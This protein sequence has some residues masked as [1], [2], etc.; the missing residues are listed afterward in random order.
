MYTDVQKWG[1]RVT[2]ARAFDPSGGLLIDS[3]WLLACA[4]AKKKKD[5]MKIDAKRKER[6]VQYSISERMRGG[7]GNARASIDRDGTGTTRIGTLLSPLGV[8]STQGWGV[9]V[10]K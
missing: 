4:F 9:C 6:T 3:R 7:V 5:S 10:S 2:C 8:A 1:C